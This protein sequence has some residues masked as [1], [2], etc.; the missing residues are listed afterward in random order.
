MKVT[1]EVINQ[2]HDANKNWIINEGTLEVINQ[3]PNA[4]KN[5]IINEG[6]LE[7]ISQWP[8]ANKTGCQIPCYHQ[9]K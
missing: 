5:W 7:V 3:W 4:N 9:Q 1:L 6:T 8:D 2:W